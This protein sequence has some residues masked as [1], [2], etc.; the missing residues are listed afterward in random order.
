MILNPFTARDLRRLRPW[1]SVIRTAADEFAIDRFVVAGLMLRE[2]AAG[3]AKPYHP[4]GDPCGWGDHGY[5]FGLFQIDRRYHKAFIESTAARF[6]LGQAR[7]ACGLLAWNRR[8]IMRRVRGVDP[9]RLTRGMLAAYNAAFHKVR[10]ALLEGR[11]PDE[12]TTGRDYSSWVIKKAHTLRRAQPAL[13]E[14]T[15]P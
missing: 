2:S 11:D 10:R 5:A 13:F 12:V 8:H 6:P 9:D 3:W 1:V 14:E 4:K 15:V 7:Y